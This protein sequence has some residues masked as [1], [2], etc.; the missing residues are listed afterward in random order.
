[1]WRKGLKGK[2]VIYIHALKNALLPVITLMGLRMG[3][4]LGGSVFVIPGM[5]SLLVNAISMQ[6]IP[7]IQGC[8]LLIALFTSVVKYAGHAGDSAGAGCGERQRRRGRR[9]GRNVPDQ[10]GA[11]PLGHDALAGQNAVLLASQNYAT[12]PHVLPC[13]SLVAVRNTGRALVY[14]ERARNIS[15]SGGGELNANGRCRFKVNDPKGINKLYTSRPDNLYTACCEDIR[16]S[17]VRFTSAAYWTL[18]PLSSRFVTLEHL[19]LDCMNTPNRDG[20][21]PVD[22]HDLSVRHCCIMAGDDGFCL[23]TADRMGCRNILAEDLVIQSLA[24]A[25]KI[26]TDSYAK[27]ENVTVRRC[28]LKN[29]NRCGIAVET[30]D[31]AAIRNCIFEDIDMT[32]C[33]G[34]MYMTIGHRN[35]K[36][37][38]FPVRMGSMA[39]I[40]FRRIGYRAPYLFSRC[41]TVYE[42]LFIGD[43]AENKIRDVLVADCDLLLPGGCRHGVDAPQPIGEKYPEYD[44]HGLSSGA[45]F[46]LRFCEDVRFENNVIQTERPD[47]RPLVMI[48]DC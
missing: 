20:I 33:G 30:V 17:D 39:H 14:A 46:T 47:V 11:A 5:G 29:V 34:P 41:K 31:G 45:A 19:M 10:T 15:I 6:D 26:G 35:R 28:I 8:V 12:Y 22:C 18:V 44:R 43:S 13:E 3:G 27:V 2:K 40:V 36:A 23:K 16:V 4:M 9:A 7:L 1:M 24:S 21:D 42:S 48:H 25:I 37:P 32:D 38:Q